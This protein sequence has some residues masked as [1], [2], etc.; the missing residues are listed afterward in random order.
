MKLSAQY[1]FDDYQI[2]E[3]FEAFVAA[4]PNGRMKKG[5]FRE[6]VEMVKTVFFYLHNHQFSTRISFTD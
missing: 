5:D 1:N 3:Y 6:M 2:R 4:H